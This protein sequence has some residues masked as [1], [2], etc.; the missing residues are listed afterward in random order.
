MTNKDKLIQMIE[1]LNEDGINLIVGLFHD[2][3]KVE[4]YNK[5]TTPE[6]IAELKQIKKQKE[7]KRKVEEE[8][9]RIEEEKIDQEFLNSH[10][11]FL[12]NIENTEPGRYCLTYGEMQALYVKSQGS[13]FDIAYDGFRAGFLKGQRAEKARQKRLREGAKAC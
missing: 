10:S 5:F 9:R 7:D 2:A 6:R 11:T 4:E 1:N 8:I 13:L 3:D 12:R